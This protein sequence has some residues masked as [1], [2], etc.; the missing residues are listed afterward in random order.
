M[1]L[2]QATALEISAAVRA[3]RIPASV[4]AEDAL[5]RIA[6][7]HSRLNAFTAVTADRARAEAAAVDAAIAAGRDPGILAGVPYAVKNLFDLAGVVTVAGSKINRD[8]PPAT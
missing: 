1:N 4:V 5:A 2:A 7:A 8:L 3:G 6:V